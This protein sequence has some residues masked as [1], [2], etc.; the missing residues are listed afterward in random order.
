MDPDLDLVVALA[1]QPD[2]TARAVLDHVHRLAGPRV[3]PAL[4]PV[5]QV[6]PKHVDE[7][8]GGEEEAGGGGV[9]RGGHPEYVIRLALAV[10]PRE[11][12]LSGRAVYAASVFELEALDED[13]LTVEVEALDDLTV[14]VELEEP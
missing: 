14:E 4:G 10:K 3:G 13:A 2:I 11:N 5:H 6:G 12:L 8:P 1:A 9:V 7:G